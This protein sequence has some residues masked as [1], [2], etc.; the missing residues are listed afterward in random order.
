MS[1]DECCIVCGEATGNG[2]IGDGSIYCAGC[3]TGPLCR[4]CTVFEHDCW[5]VKCSAKEIERLRAQVEQL[6][7]ECERHVAVIGDRNRSID[8][9]LARVKELECE[10]ALKRIGHLDRSCEWFKGVKK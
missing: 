3:E 1:D 6:T 5:C 10:I 9:G 7:E 8:K 2:G 4:W